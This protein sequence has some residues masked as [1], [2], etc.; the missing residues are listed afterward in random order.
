MA[1]RQ[2]G[3]SPRERRPDY[4]KRIGEWIKRH[5]GAYTKEHPV[6]ALRNT[7]AAFLL[8][9]AL[10]IGENR[11]FSGK[12][13]QTNISAAE[14][15]DRGKMET[16]VKGAIADYLGG[17]NDD[18]KAKMVPNTEPLIAYGNNRLGK[19]LLISN[20]RTYQVT[21]DVSQLD[22]DNEANGRTGWDGIKPPKYARIT[23][24]IP[25][26]HSSE[27][28]TYTSDGRTV[29]EEIRIRK[30][31]KDGKYHSTSAPTETH[32]AASFR[33]K[34]DEAKQFRWTY[35]ENQTAK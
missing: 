25:N 11:I 3:R 34:G 9:V 18:V 15:G 12:E 33:I 26:S 24:N 29:T 1:N 32:N 8:V 30:K 19:G 13:K 10:P 16:E 21:L 31:G 14:D 22:R 4:T 28:H 27:I 6:K 35:L 23:T 17:E 20:A 2:E 7:A 5:P